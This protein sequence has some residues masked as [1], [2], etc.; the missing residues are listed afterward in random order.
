MPAMSRARELSQLD[1]EELFRGGGGKRRHGALLRA[2]AKQAIA[3]T[4]LNLDVVGG[5]P[6]GRLGQRVRTDGS[7]ALNM[8]LAIRAT[9]DVPA[10]Q[11]R[12]GSNVLPF[13]IY[14]REC[15]DEKR[16]ANTRTIE[17]AHTDCSGLALGA[18]RGREQ[19]RLLK[20]ARPIGISQLLLDVDA[21][22]G[23][24]PICICAQHTAL[25]ISFV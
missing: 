17:T 6:G 18:G 4:H 13:S 21:V 5:D 14:I 10:A 7:S 1:L 9:V 25:M 2:A 20:R 24:I 16:P 22:L 11:H 19:G 15:T 23:R 8:C 3:G 12:F